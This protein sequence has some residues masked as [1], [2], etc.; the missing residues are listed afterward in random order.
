MATADRPISVVA[1]LDTMIANVTLPYE[2]AATVALAYKTARMLDRGGSREGF[3]PL[4]NT[5]LKQ[6]AALR[7]W[8]VPPDRNEED[9]FDALSRRLSAQVEGT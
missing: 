9:P 4:A 6:I 2:A 3:A 5:M 8:I 1:A 7:E